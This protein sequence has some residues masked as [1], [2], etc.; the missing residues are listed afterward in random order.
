MLENGSPTRKSLLSPSIE[1]QVT[2]I[3]PKLQ[4]SVVNGNIEGKNLDQNETPMVEN[5]SSTSK[6]PSCNKGLFLSEDHTGEDW[7]GSFDQGEMLENGSPASK[8][9]LS[10]SCEIQAT[11]LEPELQESVVSIEGN[12]V[13]QLTPSTNQ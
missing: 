4:E 8:T 7:D 2:N 1:V 13:D 5:V 3:E 6:E 12:Q 9:P 10:G 11:D